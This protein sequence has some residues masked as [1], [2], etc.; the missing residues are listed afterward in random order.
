M[1]SFKA[2]PQG[3]TVSH[4]V[5]VGL[6]LEIMPVAPFNSSH[7]VLEDFLKYYFGVFCFVSLMLLAFELKF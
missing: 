1:A 5:K 7:T 6:H 2:Q 4:L 3:I